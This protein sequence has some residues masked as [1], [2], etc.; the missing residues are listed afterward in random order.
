MSRSVVI[1]GAGMGGL[2]A[3]LRLARLGFA[4]R[5][6]EARPEAGGLASGCEYDGLAFDAGPYILLDRPGLEWA[7]DNLGLSLQEQVP[8]R[9]IEEVYEVSFAGGAPVR[10]DAD[11]AQTAQGLEQTW[12]GSGRRYIDFIESI[13]RKY[14]R[15]RPLQ[16]VSHPGLLDLVR[17]GAWRHALFLL[18][19]LHAVHAGT[20]LPEPVL[21]ALAIWTHV[22]GQRAE[23]APSPLAF[24]P[25]LIHG[26]GCFYPAAGIRS[27]PQ[28]LARAAAAAGVDFE[29]G[30]KVRAIRCE[31]GR[32]RGVTTEKGAFIAAD[33]VVADAG[34]V[35][36]YLDLVDATPPAA[37]ERLQRLPLQSPGVCTYLA[38]KGDTRPPYLRFRLPG[39]GEL[40]RLLIRPATLVPECVRDGWQPARLLGPMAYAQAQRDGPAGQREYL[41]RLLEEPWWREGVTDF[42]V[43]ATR[44][45]AEWG[46]QYHLYRDSMNPVMTAAFMRA[47]RLAH[48][49]PYVR[50]LYLAGSSTHP[51]QWV[52]FCAVSGILAADRLREDFA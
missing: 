16:Q 25:A 3:A 19:S 13:G 37:R 52:S 11:L 22:A 7:F 35:G 41:Q 4:V 34:G 47:G 9:R 31:A 38:I 26:V 18:R 15:L 40:C 12:P 42:R 28:V 32:A 36:V 21:D 29:Y 33:A 6:L 17:T 49:S 46:A 23:E 43:L 20:G 48:R 50:G 44:V 5:V 24:V 14:E 2:S 51:G 30:T 45:P 10:I 8:L 1:V 39:G 27:I